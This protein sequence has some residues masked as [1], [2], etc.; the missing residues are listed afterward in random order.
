MAIEMAVGERPVVAR[1]GIGI[2]HR[3]WCRGPQKQDD[4]EPK[5]SEPNQPY[6]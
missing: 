3:K 5:P 4:K 6:P 1:L 2:R